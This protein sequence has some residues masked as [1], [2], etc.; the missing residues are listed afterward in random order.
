MSSEIVPRSAVPA[1]DDAERGTHEPPRPVQPTYLADEKKDIFA[2]DEKKAVA[3][4]EA[5]PATKKETHAAPA[6][7][8]TPK[9]KKKVSKWILW[10]LWFN[11]YRKLFTFVFS[12]N[13]I[14]IG[15]AASGHFPYA[16]KY[17]GAMAV[18]NFNFAI[19]MRNEIFG[20]LLYLFVNTLFAK[21]T[22]LKFRLACTSVLQHLGG[23]HSGC[24]L[25]GVGWLILKVVTVFRHRHIENPS[26]LVVGLL[27]NLAVFITAM[28]A[29]PWVR[30]THHNIF[31]RHHRFVGWLALFLTWAFTLMNDL[32]DTDTQTWN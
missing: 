6:A 32:Y 19:L 7:K 24:A 9:P 27:T 23:I 18:A 5:I 21:W 10:Q 12:I 28:S 3:T 29:M 17:N 16:V 25:S 31:E 30:N 4:I 22:P 1:Y 15:L 20:R 8:P 14:G 13:M 26:I 11:T 2:N